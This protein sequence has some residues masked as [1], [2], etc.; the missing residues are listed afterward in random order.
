MPM[1]EFADANGVQWKVWNTI[2]IATGVAGSMQNGWL[3]FASSGERR[4]LAPIPAGWE[5]A[6]PERLCLY[7]D[8]AERLPRTTYLDPL[9][10]ETHRP[11]DSDR[12]G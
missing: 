3:T 2:P 12:A 8:D 1:R 4:R 11:A 10:S 6:A 5:A 9:L 7:C